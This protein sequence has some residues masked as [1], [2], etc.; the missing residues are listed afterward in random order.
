MEKL[1]L[2]SYNEQN[3]FL[4]NNN[5]TVSPFIKWAGGKRALIPAISRF[6]PFESL[7]IDTYI[8]PFVGSGAILF[9]ILNKFT[10]K[11]IIIN[12]INAQLISTYK[13]IQ[14]NP[15]ILIKKL[16]ELKKYFFDLSQT[17]RSDFYYEIRNIYNK[18]IENNDF[19]TAD[20]AASFIFLNKTCYNGLYRVNKKG[21]FNVPYGSY[22]NPSIFDEDNIYNISKLLKN[23]VILNGVY[24]NTLEFIDEN[25]FV[26]LD[27]PYRPLS[28]SSSFTSYAKGDFNDYDQIEL[29]NFI[30]M[31]DNRRAKF[32]LSNSDPKNTDINDNFF[33]D[34]YTDFKIYR[35]SA[36]RSINSDSSKRGFVNELLITN[37]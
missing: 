21:L 35:I 13:F 30:K 23:V 12:D 15:S 22:K 17:K 18:N 27:P 11:N 25:T 20:M 6:Y 26:Y 28:S 5:I 29:S 10:L 16:R 9:D 33:D 14:L 37:I 24:N 32:I 36:K 19:K 2:N 4:K 7:K 1:S 31:I 34:L 3:S 8:E